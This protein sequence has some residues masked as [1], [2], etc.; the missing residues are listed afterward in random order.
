MA[1]FETAFNFMM[2]NEDQ[3]RHYAVVPDAPA[4][5]H[6]ISGIN[7]HAFPADFQQIS[8]IGQVARG[9]SIQRFYELHFWNS[10]LASITS[11][12]VAMRVFDTAVNE[13]YFEAIKLLQEAANAAVGAY[14][15]VDGKSGPATLNVVNNC[16]PDM[17]AAAFRQARVS[18]YRAIALNNPAL[19][20]YL[21]E[22]LAR[23]SK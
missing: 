3:G 15:V 23:A 18:R 4:G 9:P 10:F 1:S 19:A 14:L 2:N 8:Q 12:Q 6:A 16:N 7:S 5:A 13:G 17:L 20:Q 22:W 11:D 21:N